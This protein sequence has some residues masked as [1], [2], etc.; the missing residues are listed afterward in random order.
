M[1][2]VW[3]NTMVLPKQQQVYRIDE[4]NDSI[5]KIHLMTEDL[6]QSGPTDVVIMVKSV[7][8]N[9]RDVMV[10]SGTYFLPVKKQV[11]PCSDFAGQVVHVG[12]DVNDFEVGDYAIGNMNITHFSGVAKRFDD[13]LGAAI[14]GGLQEYVVLPESGVNKVPKTADL[15][16]EEM[17]SLVCTG[18]TCWNALYGDRKL[19]PGQVVLATGTGGVS[20]TALSI[21]KKAGAV[22]VITSSSDE[23]IAKIQ[24]EHGFDYAVN[25]KTN[26]QWG[27]EVK[28]LTGGADFVIE[29]A[30]ASGYVQAFEACSRGAVVCAIGNLSPPKQE[31]IP[32]TCMLTL[33]HEASLRG[34]V[35]GSQEL[36]RQ[37]IKFTDAK[38]LKIPIDKVFPFEKAVEALEYLVSGA[39]IGKVCIR[40]SE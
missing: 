22:T 23:K 14:D 15:T 2:R 6:P 30:G 40:V 31:E 33:L 24:K 4:Q 12:Q 25:Y 38:G 13:A 3:V 19:V 35:I 29:N 37:L 5:R 9:Y 34:I 36:V 10:A 21:A 39:H 16:W 26:K 18:A 1:G 20:L 32:D 17:A 27:K 7:A 8:L 11:V 28:K